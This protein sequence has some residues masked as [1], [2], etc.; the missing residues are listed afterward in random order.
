MSKH[1]K[2]TLNELQALW[3]LGIMAVLV[4]YLVYL[5]FHAF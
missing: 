3:L 5:L 1:R 4:P 2:R